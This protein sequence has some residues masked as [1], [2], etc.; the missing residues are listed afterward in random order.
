[1][2]KQEMQDYFQTLPDEKE[3]EYEKALKKYSQKHNTVADKE[4]FHEVMLEN[5][6]GSYEAFV[7]LATIHR[8]NKDF[9]ELHNLIE[10]AGE[11]G[12][13]ANR[14][15]F[16]HI[17]IMYNVH[18]ETLFDYHDML[19]KAHRQACEMY[20]NSGYHHTFANTFA[21]ICEHCLPSDEKKIID[22]W[23]DAALFCVNRAIELDPK[24]AKFYSTK[25]RIVMLKHNYAEAQELMLRAIDLE[26]SEQFDYAILIGNY[27]YYRTMI[28]LHEQRYLLDVNDIIVRNTRDDKEITKLPKGFKMHYPFAFISYSHSDT[29]KVAAIINRLHQYNINVWSDAE[30]VGGSDW[31]DMIAD[32]VNKCDVLILMIS[33][34]ALLS[35]NV[36]NELTMAQNHKKKIV[37]VFLE[38]VHLSLGAELQLQSYHHLYQYDLA[39]DRFYSELL[40]AVGSARLPMDS[41]E[42]L[43]MDSAQT[44]VEVIENKNQ[45]TDE[46]KEIIEVFTSSKTGRQ[47]DNEDLIFINEDFIAIFDGATS[48]DNNTY[49]GKTA[50]QLAVGCL[51]NIMESKVFDRMID[52]QT[53][54]TLLQAGLCDFE[55]KHKLAEKQM[56]LCAAGVIYSKARHQ[57]WSVGDCQYAINGAVHSEI[58]KVDEMMSAARTLAIHCLMLDG[59]T[60]ADIET[61]DEARELILGILKIQHYLENADDE[62]GYSVF[63]GKGHIKDVKI[64]NVAPGSEVILASDGYPELKGTLQ[65]SEERLNELKR[66]DPLCYKEYR[67]TKGLVAGNESF[68][69]RSYLRFRTE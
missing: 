69:D 43:P 33:S 36:R 23:Y 28:A 46:S 34:S 4:L 32:Y 17:E 10:E 57:I 30:L 22:E 8:H 49:Q 41:F 5:T 40:E 61:K 26:K 50:G 1:M 44:A 15:S 29:A 54:T 39:P 48:K 62:F 45:T 16:T 35:Q 11:I 3:R 51:K 37:P 60:E 6:D 24:Y 31:A 65:K 14:I 12:D 66:N 56:H 38:Q 55:K 63:S 21:T 13:F 58:K 7:C 20:D 68:D 27:Q 52:G 67:S 25:A 42:A 2:T 19:S 47:E 53:A 18:S 64:I 9:T 59:R